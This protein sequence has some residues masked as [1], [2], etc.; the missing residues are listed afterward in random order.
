MDADQHQAGLR[1]QEHGGNRKE[2]QLH[3]QEGPIA[4]PGVHPVEGKHHQ[5]PGQ[6]PGSGGLAQWQGRDERYDDYRQGEQHQQQVPTRLR[7]LS[8][9]GILG[10]VGGRTTHAASPRDGWAP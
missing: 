6:Q 4:K 8:L 3:Q 10:S 9:A 5:E 2:H 7:E 1:G